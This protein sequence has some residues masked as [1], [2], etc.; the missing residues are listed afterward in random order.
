M[1]V[2]AFWKFLRLGNSVWDFLGVKFWSRD[3]LGFWFLPPIDH[4]CYLKSRVPPGSLTHPLQAMLCCCTVR[5]TT[6]QYSNKHHTI[7]WWGEGRRADCFSP[8]EPHLKTVSQHFVSDCSL[9]KLSPPQRFEC[10]NVFHEHWLR[11]RQMQITLF[12]HFSVEK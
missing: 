10:Q 6:K 7:E 5:A 1:P 4:P 9:L 3:F 11:Q 8:Q 2:S 12:R